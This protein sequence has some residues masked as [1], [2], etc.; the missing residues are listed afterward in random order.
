MTLMVRPTQATTSIHASDIQADYDLYEPFTNDLTAYLNLLLDAAAIGYGMDYTNLPQNYRAAIWSAIDA[1]ETL[2]YVADL[3]DPA[4]LPTILGN[5]T[6]VMWMTEAESLAS[7]GAKVAHALKIDLDGD[8]GWRLHDMTVEEL[9]SLLDPDLIFEHGWVPGGP[10]GDVL[11]QHIIDHSPKRAYDYASV[12]MGSPGG[13]MGAALGNLCD[14]V[15]DDTSYRHHAVGNYDNA[16]TVDVPMLTLDADSDWVSRNGCHSASRWLT[17]LSRSINIPGHYIHSYFGLEST[18]HGTAVFPAQD[19]VLGHGDNIYGS[20]H[21]EDAKALDRFESWAYWKA[22]VIGASE[23][24]QEFETYHQYWTIAATWIAH[25]RSGVPGR[26]TA[27]F[28]QAGGWADVLSDVSAYFDTAEEA[29]LYADLAY[30]T[31]HDGG[32]GP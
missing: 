13:S 27:R 31:Q 17:A 30:I 24:N 19:A 9:Q 6:Y 25:P 20:G 16:T 11:W 15:E 3:S 14:Y 10:S 26:W 8:V 29:Q 7:Y 4:A 21:H 2:G 22:N 1:A 28:P 23:A 12:W 5:T 32:G 18:D